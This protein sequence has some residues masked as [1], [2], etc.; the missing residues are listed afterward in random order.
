MVKEGEPIPNYYPRIV[1]DDLFYEV[2]AIFAHNDLLLGRGGGVNTTIAN[3][4]GHIT[5][6]TRVQARHDP[7]QQRRRPWAARRTSNAAGS[8]M[9]SAVARAGFDTTGFW[10]Y[11]YAYARGL[12]PQALS[13]DG[14]EAAQEQRAAPTGA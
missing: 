7:Q 6:C 10:H 12:D 11:S 14:I 5:R 1:D 13:T 3:V 9:A 8:R 2:Q 4:F